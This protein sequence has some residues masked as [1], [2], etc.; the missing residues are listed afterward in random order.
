MKFLPKGDWVNQAKC[1]EVDPEIFFP[2][3][4]SPHTSRVARKICQD[5]QVV[6]HCLDYAIETNPQYGIF[7]GTTVDDRIKIRRGWGV[8]ETGGAD[9]TR[10]K[11]MAHQHKIGATWEQIG[12]QY[13]TEPAVVRRSV[14]TY[15]ARS[16]QIQC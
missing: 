4:P 11:G 14:E 10:V 8:K 12:E 5:C 13:N 6:R 1:L 7:A 16:L 9:M 15:L 3:V 2:E